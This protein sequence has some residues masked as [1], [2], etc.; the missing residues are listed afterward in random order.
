MSH[1]SHINRLKK[2]A[3]SFFIAGVVLMGIAPVVENELMLIGGMVFVGS[4]AVLY[5]KSRRKPK[6]IITKAQIEALLRRSNNR[7]TVQSLAQL[8]KTT[9]DFAE[10]KLQEYVMDNILDVDVE[11]TDV[12]YRRKEL[13]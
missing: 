11:G 7:I 10:Q 3:R 1:Q 13:Y 4:S 6:Q 8:T 5:F 2:K 12:V 9:P